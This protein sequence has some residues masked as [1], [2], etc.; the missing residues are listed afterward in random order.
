M[1]YA[2][3]AFIRAVRNIDEDLIS[4][5]I[6]KAITYEDNSKLRDINLEDCGSFLNGKL[7]WLERAIQGLKEAKS[8]KKKKEKEDFAR[9]IEREI[10]YG[11]RSVKSQAEDLAN[12]LERFEVD[13]PYFDPPILNNFLK[14]KV[15]FRWRKSIEEPFSEGSITFLHKYTDN[16]PVFRRSMSKRFRSSKKERDFQQDLSSCWERMQRCGIDSLKE[17]FRNGGEPKDVPEVFTMR[18]CDYTG[19]LNNH[20]AKFWDHKGT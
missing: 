8:P 15:R 19:S 9:S 4:D 6:D 7:M 12:D 13:E 2:D 1:S 18:V 17:F 5:I 14:V 20:S 10:S 16:P 3:E 11:I